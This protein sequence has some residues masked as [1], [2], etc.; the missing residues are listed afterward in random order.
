MLEIDL[1]LL[2]TLNVTIDVLSSTLDYNDVTSMVVACWP[3]V[4]MVVALP[5][6][7]ATPALPHPIYPCSKVQGKATY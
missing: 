1:A 7:Q 4:H 3:C 5:K 2:L 6:Q